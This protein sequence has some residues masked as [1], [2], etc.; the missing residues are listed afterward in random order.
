VGR[1]GARRLRLQRERAEQDQ[2]RENRN[3]GRRGRGKLELLHRE[4]SIPDRFRILPHFAGRTHDRFEIMALRIFF[5]AL[6]K[7]TSRRQ[8]VAKAGVHWQI[9]LKASGAYR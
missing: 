3:P 1:G 7:A 8:A 4:A 2:R 9:V 5:L 6:I